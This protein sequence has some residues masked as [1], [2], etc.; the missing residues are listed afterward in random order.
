MKFYVS[1]RASNTHAVRKA[2]AEIKERGHEITFEWSDPT[3]RSAKPFHENRELAAEYA[4]QA[5]QG[6]VDADVYI[7]IS[8]KDGNGVFGELGAALGM[9]AKTGSPH[10]YAIG[11]KEETM[12]HFH[13]AIQW[14]EDV[15]KVIDELEALK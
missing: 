8:T 13:P 9:N 5:I 12:F 10:L 11:A 14:R 2:V 1:G 3:L 6:V 4:S 7:M 15:K